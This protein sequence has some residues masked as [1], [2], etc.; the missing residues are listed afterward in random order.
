MKIAQGQSDDFVMKEL[1]SR[2]ATKR[3]NLNLTQEELAVRA[4]VSRPTIQ[5]LEEGNSIQFS[6]MLRVLRALGLI[7]N[8]EV[9]V[10]ES[11][12]SPMMLVKSR[13]DERKRASSGD[14]LINSLDP[15]WKWGDE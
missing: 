7:T 11:T 6:N 12:V 8:L 13:S 10:P 9:L 2:L 5:R 15:N 14:A 3:L 1:G 4:G